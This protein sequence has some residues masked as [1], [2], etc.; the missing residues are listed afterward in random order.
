MKPR[1]GLSNIII[2]VLLLAISV[3]IAGLY[4]NWAPNFSENITQKTVDQTDHDI[5]CRNAALSIKDPV[6]DDSANAVLFDLE[7]SGTIRFTEG[8]R[9][10]AFNS[11]TIIN[12]TTVEG[13]EVGDSV[14]Q[15]LYSKEKPDMILATSFECP[16]LSVKRT[17]IEAQ[18]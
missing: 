15:R 5:K 16:S 6:H 17:T 12:E 4:S 11:S 13:L 7:N 2:T 3:S 18:D 9:V 10:A 8:I 14:A 1:K